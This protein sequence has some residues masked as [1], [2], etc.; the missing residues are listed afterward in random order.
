LLEI[1]KINTYYGDAH[2]LHD[3]SAQVERDEIVGLLGRNGAG[4]T[5]T[6]KSVIGL[7]PPQTGRIRFKGEP[8][9]GDDP[10]DIYRRGVGYIAEDRAIFPDLTVRENL[11]VGLR[12]GQ[13][14]DFEQVFEYFP[15]LEERLG[16]KGGTLSG[17]EQ[18]ML[19]IARTV[20]SNPDLL[21]IDE[22]TEGLM[23]TL[24]EGIS[25]I[26]EQLNEDD[27]TIFLVEQNIDLVLD[28][29]DRVY[30]VSQGAVRF[31][32]TPKELENDRETIDRHL[33]V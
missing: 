12:S 33:A 6:L 26:V 14:P 1:E 22:P 21:L 30:V 13:D 24:V 15:R 16:Q 11:L 28:I 3:V 8:I 20:V 10:E 29:A 5:T 7:Q 9:Q 32:G 31:S 19:A 4:K 27:H 23:P 2:V 17:G 18:Q 25:E